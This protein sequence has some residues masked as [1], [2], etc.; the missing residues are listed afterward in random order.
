M[1]IYEKFRKKADEPDEP[2]CPY[3][4]KN[5]G[6]TFINPNPNCSLL[7]CRSCD[8]KGAYYVKEK[9]KCEVYKEL[10]RYKIIK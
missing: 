5:N 7:L 4:M 8:G 2:I 10:V 6:S 3:Y 9:T 1:K